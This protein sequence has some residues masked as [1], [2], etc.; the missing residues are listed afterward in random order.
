[1]KRRKISPHIEHRHL[2]LACDEP[3]CGCALDDF[4]LRPRGQDKYEH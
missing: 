1:M 2:D 3:E 4:A